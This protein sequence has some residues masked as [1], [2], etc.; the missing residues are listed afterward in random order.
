MPT[1]EAGIH[2]LLFSQV[3]I[4]LGDTAANNGATVVRIWWKPMVTLIWLGAVAMAI[5]GAIS[6][7]DRRLRVGAPARR[8]TV[9]AA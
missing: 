5:G 4:A 9:K 6:L 7:S 1:T 3:Y 8:R 2:T